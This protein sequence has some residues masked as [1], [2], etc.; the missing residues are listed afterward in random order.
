VH[1]THK[2]HLKAIQH[3]ARLSLLGMAAGFALRKHRNT[4]QLAAIAK[5]VRT[6]YSRGLDKNDEFEADRVGVVLAARAGY[7]PYGLPA[8]L[9]MLDQQDPKSG[10]LA[11]LLKTHPKASDRL[12]RLTSEMQGR[13]DDLPEAVE[14]SSRFQHYLAMLGKY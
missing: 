12:A 9:E 13:L 2:H 6:V 1:V 4:Q 14:G 10:R 5:G 8:V 7:D 11:L 3:E